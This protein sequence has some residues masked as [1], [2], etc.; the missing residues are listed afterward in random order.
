M[1]SSLQQGANEIRSY[2]VGH[3]QFVSCSAFIS[4]GDLSLLAT[5]SGDGSV[6]H[7]PA[8]APLL[9]LLRLL[10]AG[11]CE[12]CWLVGHSP[13]VTDAC[14]L[15]QHATGLL[16]ETAQLTQPAQAD[17]G[18][19]GAAGQHVIDPAASEPPGIAGGST[20]D[21][22]PAAAGAAT[23]EVDTLVHAEGDVAGDDDGDDDGGLQQQ[24]RAS[25]HPAVLAIAV[26][27]SGC[28]ALTRPEPRRSPALYNSLTMPPGIRAVY[29]VLVYAKFE[30]PCRR[31]IAA[32]LEGAD[33]VVLL[34]AALRRG[35]NCGLP[36]GVLKVAQRLA[37]PELR[38]PFAV[39]FQPDGRLWA[40]G[41]A[42]DTDA[43]NRCI[44]LCTA[45]RGDGHQEGPDS[46]EVRSK[47]S[48][49]NEAPCSLPSWS[50]CCPNAACSSYLLR[51]LGV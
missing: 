10:R 26:S 7:A 51:V 6:R 30:W 27:P 38:Q 33:E 18:S 24:R 9:H 14:R 42:A 41:I 12:D 1:R 11:C 50:S 20:A 37:L 35:R 8:A 3:T 48:G 46:P 49:S 31:T 34:S 28:V 25:T 44:V 17:T 32:V 22:E 5:G 36:K 23:A 43:D 4:Q 40:A 16:A 29:F 19:A 13:S 15:W 2:C 47:H 21:A 45:D 39:A